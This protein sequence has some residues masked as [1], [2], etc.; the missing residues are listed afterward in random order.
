VT[1]RQV[2]ND[3]RLAFNANM[4]FIT[5]TGEDVDAI[6]TPDT[7][8]RNER[9]VIFHDG[10]KPNNFARVYPNGN[11]VISQRVTLDLS[12]PGLKDFETTGKATCSMDIAS[13]NDI[14]F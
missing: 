2:F 12:C 14:I 5:L 9:K 4:E 10:L 7:F 1:L 3:T 6:W 8:I 13:C 11:V